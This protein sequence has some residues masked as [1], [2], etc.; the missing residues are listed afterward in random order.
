MF[1]NER[2]TFKVLLWFQ[3]NNRS[4]SL[5]NKIQ[6]VI[7]MAK[8]ESLVMVIHELQRRGTTNIPEKGSNNIIIPKVSRN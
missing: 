2:E 5:E 1:L 6:V 3:I 7:L 4:H 8:Y